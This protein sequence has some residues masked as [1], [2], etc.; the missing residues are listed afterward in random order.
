MADN[1]DKREPRGC[2]WIEEDLSE[3]WGYCQKPQRRKS[4]FCEEH[5]ARCYQSEI[6]E[7]EQEI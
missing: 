4:A 2:R 7:T 3:D 1:V 6:K 5:H